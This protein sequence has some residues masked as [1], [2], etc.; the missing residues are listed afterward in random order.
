MM[1]LQGETNDYTRLN[2]LPVGVT[3]SGPV[4]SGVT[5]DG[6]QSTVELGKMA[7]D[8]KVDYAVR[9]IKQLTGSGK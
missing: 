9:Q 3:V 8:M 4:P 1:Y 6:R 2:L 7:F 5:G